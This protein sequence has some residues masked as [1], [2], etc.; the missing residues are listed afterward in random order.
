[1]SKV[2]LAGPL[3]TYAEIEFN[4]Q[5][6]GQ[7][8]LEAPGVDFA[9]PQEFCASLKEPRAIMEAC[10]DQLWSSDVVA[11]NCDG[12]DVDSGTAFEAGIAYGCH[13]PIVC[14][15]TDF[16]RAGDCS[17]DMNLMLAYAGSIVDDYRDTRT[18]GI[19]LAY[20]VKRY[21]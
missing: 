7:L 21:L 9:V 19:K 14:Y 2:Y 12:P 11:V 13:I 16:R 3:F 4:R 20:E 8:R 18:L 1:M 10:R 5:L 6:A 15:R 17:S